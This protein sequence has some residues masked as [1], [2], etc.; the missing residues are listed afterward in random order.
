MQQG[1]KAL[2]GREPDLEICGQVASGVEAL[3]QIP[4]CSPDVVLVDISLSGDMNGIELV[5][6]LQARLPDLPVLVVSGY[7][8]SVYTELVLQLGAKGYL[9]KGD[10][11]SFIKA[12]RTVLAGDLYISEQ[13]RRNSWSA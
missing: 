9:M 5:R 6:Q 10:A 3:A 8:E 1:Y 11:E 2:V 4:S 7:D 12:I 13:T